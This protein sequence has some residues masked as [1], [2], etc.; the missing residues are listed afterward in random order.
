MLNFFKGVGKSKKT[1]VFYCLDGRHGVR[2]VDKTSDRFN[3]EL[4][5]DVFSLLEI[6][7]QSRSQACLFW[8]KASPP[9]SLI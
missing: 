4:Q 1:D 5:V 2:K 3:H 7:G 8:G 9:E 6:S